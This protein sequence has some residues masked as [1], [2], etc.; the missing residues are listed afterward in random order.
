MATST[1]I[2]GTKVFVVVY[3][4]TDCDYSILAILGTRLEAYNYI[5]VE[6]NEKIKPVSLSFKLIKVAKPSDVIKQEED[7]PGTMK[8]CYIT[9]GRYHKFN[10]YDYDNVSQYAIISMTIL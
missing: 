6:E 1:P 3:N 7:D 10:M 9:T 8:I 5:V 2:K 4:Y